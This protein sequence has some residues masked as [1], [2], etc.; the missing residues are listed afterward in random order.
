MG[1]LP[2]AAAIL[3]IAAAALSSCS[4]NHSDSSL[5]RRDDGHDV[6]LQALTWSSSVSLSDAELQNTSASP[7]TI[8]SVKARTHT[9]RIVRWYVVH[10]DPGRQGIAMGFP[11]RTPIDKNNPIVNAHES[12]GIYYQ[13]RTSRPNSEVVSNGIRV[14]YSAKGGGGEVDAGVNVNI[15]PDQKGTPPTAPAPQGS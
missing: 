7:V 9:F 3:A 11:W 4:N 15:G 13:I 14:A 2:A 6:M 12:V 8:K 1:R 10:G 5:V